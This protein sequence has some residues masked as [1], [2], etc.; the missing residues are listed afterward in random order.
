MILI[1]WLRVLFFDVLLVVAGWYLFVVV[2][3][4]ILGGILLFSMNMVIVWVR[5]V[6]RC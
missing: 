6:D 1:R 2:K 5:L 3:V 4:I